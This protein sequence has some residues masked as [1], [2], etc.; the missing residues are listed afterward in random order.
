MYSTDWLER[1]APIGPS[2]QHR[3]D[4][5]HNHLGHTST[6]QGTSENSHIIRVPCVR[7]AKGVRRQL[8]RVSVEC[9]RSVLGWWQRN[10]AVIIT[11]LSPHLNTGDKSLIFTGVATDPG[12]TVGFC[13]VCSCDCCRFC[14]V[15]VGPLCFSGLSLLDRAV[16]LFRVLLCPRGVATS[17]RALRCLQRFWTLL[18]AVSGTRERMQPLATR[19]S[20][21]GRGVE[22][23]VP[24]LH[25]S[26]RETGLLP[27]HP[28]CEVLQE[29][30]QCM[31]SWLTSAHIPIASNAR[32]EEHSQGSRKP[33]RGLQE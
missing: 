20:N 25:F 30:G 10:K 33:M 12:P 29:S 9:S 19:T 22:R 2:T 3:S 18:G 11:Y 17:A 16:V 8:D 5:G 15:P 28:T 1:T 6:I 14:V 24:D 26:E 32:A 31:K 23:T 27:L 7:G 13:L 21:G 4:Q